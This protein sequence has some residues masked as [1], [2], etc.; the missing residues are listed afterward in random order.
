MAINPLISLQG[1]T[2]DVGQAISNAL[3]NV[4]RIKAMQQ[5]G[6][7]QDAAAQRQQAINEIIG[8][9]I[10]GRQELG[11]PQE[12][13]SAPQ[14]GGGRDAELRRLTLQQK[15][16]LAIKFPDEFEKINAGLGLIDEEQKAQS[17]DFAFKLQRTPFE[18]RPQIIQQ[19]A[20]FLRSRGRDPKEIE[21]L[22]GLDQDDQDSRLEYRQLAALSPEKRIEV[23]KGTDIATYAPQIDPITGE[24]FFPGFDKKSQK[25]VRIDVPGAKGQT[26]EQEIQQEVDLTQRK[27][28]I[29][30]SEAGEKEQQKLRAKRGNEDIN[31]GFAASQ[32]VPNLKRSIDLL[33]E[34]ETG[35]IDA[36]R[37][38]AKQ[39]LGIESGNEAELVNAMSKQVIAQLRPVFGSQFTKAE[40]DWLKAIEAG[41]GKSTA[42]NIRLLKRGLVLA[43]RR[44]KIG[45][46][47]AIEAKDF[48]KAE[49]IQEFLDSTI[50]P[51]TESA[52]E[53][54]AAAPKRIRFDSQGN[55][56]Q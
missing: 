50:G 27:S 39:F 55:I 31:T 25:A 21:S 22:I 26:A 17:A 28:D 41:S 20:D 7:A 43:E 5:Q 37:L 30:A 23:S 12:E 24:I 32:A 13:Q 49:E 48:R 2:P 16:E 46:K 18:Q 34:I 47:A 35:G 9:P 42:G 3:L 33:K 45:L 56:I 36:I 53:P 44:S 51:A 8:R 4:G 38:K 11:A 54:A 6:Q 14:Q 1:R 29:K 40:G 19:R 15:A 10:G 52:Q